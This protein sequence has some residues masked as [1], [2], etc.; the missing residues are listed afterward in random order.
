[1]TEKILIVLTSHEQLGNTGE[2]TGF[3]LE[4]LA[5]PYYVFIDAGAEVTLASPQGG[6]PPADPR[7]DA[8][9]SKT[10]ATRRFKGDEN[11]QAKLARTHRLAEVEASDYDA[12]FFPGGHG[13]LWDLVSDPHCIGLIEHFWSDGKPVAAVCHGPVVLMHAE[14]GNGDPIVKGRDVTGFSN[15]EEQAVELA[16]VVPVSVE[17][18]LKKRGGNYAKNQDF[19][20]FVR[21]DGKLVTGQNPASSQAV[22]ER[23]LEALRDTGA[24]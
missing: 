2:K 1:M 19:A 13:P 15:S 10:G 12:V 16:D 7:S 22:A 17:D 20:V 14:D 4:E 5:A 6:R 3:W 11:A 23:L 9:D 21:R 18:M 8:E 24:G